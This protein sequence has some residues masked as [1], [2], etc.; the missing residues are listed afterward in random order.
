MTRY[1]PNDSFTSALRRKTFAAPTRRRWSDPSTPD[2]HKLVEPEPPLPTAEEAA[3]RFWNGKVH[4]RQSMTSTLCGDP[5][6]SR[7]ALSGFVAPFEEAPTITRPA[8]SMPRF[9]WERV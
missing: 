9:S 8:P 5:D 6:P 3:A 7:S 1:R 4:E 2:T